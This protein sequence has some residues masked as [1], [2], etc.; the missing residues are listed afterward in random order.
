MKL[1]L[2]TNATTVDDATRFMS[3]H[4]RQHRQQLVVEQE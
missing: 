1:E 2:L 3:E 4:Q